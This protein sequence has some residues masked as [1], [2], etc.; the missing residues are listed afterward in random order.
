M[1]KLQGAY[2]VRALPAKYSGNK[3]PRRRH[4]PSTTG[5]WHFTL[6]ARLLKLKLGLHRGYR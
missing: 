4:L 6:G 3:P 1:P 2:G 5:R